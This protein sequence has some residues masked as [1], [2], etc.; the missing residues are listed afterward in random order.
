MTGFIQQQPAGVVS[1][2]PQSQLQP[3]APHTAGVQEIPFDQKAIQDHMAVQALVRSY[4]V[5][6]LTIFLLFCISL[7]KIFKQISKTIS[8]KKYAVT[9]AWTQNSTT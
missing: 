5:C 6:I 4:Q 9:D 8:F 7:L 3:I 1:Q 2:Q